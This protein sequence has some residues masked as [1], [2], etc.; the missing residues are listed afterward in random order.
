MYF[1]SFFK[2]PKGGDYTS[3]K[4]KNQNLE[5]NFD[6]QTRNHTADVLGIGRNKVSDA[7]TVLDMTG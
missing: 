7:R 2:N 4:Y 6:S 5:V 3:E 1:L